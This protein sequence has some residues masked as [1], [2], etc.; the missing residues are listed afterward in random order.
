A[1]F[2]AATAPAAG[3]DGAPAAADPDAALAPAVA[4]FV[5]DAGGE[6]AADLDDVVEVVFPADLGDDP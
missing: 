2:T 6:G 3:P 1:D 5:T 4:D